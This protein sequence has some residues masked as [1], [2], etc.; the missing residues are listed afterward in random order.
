MQILQAMLHLMRVEG[1]NPEEESFFSFSCTSI[2]IVNVYIDYSDCLS[3]EEQK[4]SGRHGF[5]QF[6][7]FDFLLIVNFILELPF[8][9][10][11]LP[12]H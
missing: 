8:K 4:V 6:Q 9:F 2:F 7:I 12:Q 1:T 10:K 3:I 5:D 11:Y